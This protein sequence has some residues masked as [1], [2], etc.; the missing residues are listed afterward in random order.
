MAKIILNVEID[1]WVIEIIVIANI[2][3]SLY[4]NQT[5]QERL[6]AIEKYGGDPDRNL[7]LNYI[8]ESRLSHLANYKSIYTI[9]LMNMNLPLF[10]QCP[11]PLSS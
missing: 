2:R 1:N 11:A 10:R 9:I 5:K 3:C 8:L 6:F 4:V 7:D